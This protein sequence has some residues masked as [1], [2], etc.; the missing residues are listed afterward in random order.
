MINKKYTRVKT[1][2]YNKLKDFVASRKYVSLKQINSFLK[3][4]GCNYSRETIQKYLRKLKQ[5]KILFSAGRGYY[6][7]NKKH[8]PINDEGFRNL[9]DLIKLKYPLLEFSLWSTKMLAPLFHHTQNQF[10]TFIYSE[11]DSLIYL[12]DLLTNN[13]FKVYLN[14]SKND[15]EKN[16]LLANSIILRKQI[17]RGQTKKNIAC[18]EKIIVDLFMESKRLGLIDRSEYENIF[19]NSLNS[20]LINLSNLLDYAQRR[21]NREEFKNLITKYTNVTFK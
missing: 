21:K 12:R 1:E 6:S 5:E 16:P 13:G 19:K 17:E 15:I 20:Y 9:I 18:I 4:V 2:A 10:H 7:T 14:P 11:T 3:E 8:F